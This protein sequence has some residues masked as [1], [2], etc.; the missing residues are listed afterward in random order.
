MKNKINKIILFILFLILLL[1]FINNSFLICNVHIF[2]C[3]NDNCSKCLIIQNIQDMLKNIF[4]MIYISTVFINTKIIDK[5]IIFVKNTIYNNL[6]FR[7][8]ILNE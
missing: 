6:V 5:I 4:I 3:K 1:M 7:K 8:V 2:E